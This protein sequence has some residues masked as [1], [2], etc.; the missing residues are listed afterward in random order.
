MQSDVAQSI[1]RKV[2]VT[3]AGEEQARLSSA[4]PVS[5]EVYET[6]RK[7]RFAKSN[8]QQELERN[9]A[10]FE[11]AISKDP[12]FA[13]A[14]VGLA[15][16]YDSLATVF[17]GAPPEGAREKQTRAALKALE[18]DSGNAEA[19]VLLAHVLR[20]Q[21]HW[22]NAEAEYK[23]ALALNPNDA[24]AHV[25]CATWFLCQGQTEE[26][27]AWSRRAREL[28]PLGPTG[29]NI[30]YILFGA[31]HYDE[32][33][34]DMQDALALRPDDALAHWFLGFALIAKDQPAEAIPEL[35]KAVA[36]TDYGPGAIGV[37]IRAYAHAGRRKV[38]L[39]LLA[40]LKLR[41]HAGYVASGAFVNAYLG[42]GDNAQAFV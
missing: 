29:T 4:R 26:A 27:V 1:A 9:I 20:K 37:L 38:A 10:S 7:G 16:A 19:H 40:D 28:D 14:Y 18:L 24:A 30:G 17:V 5:P 13:P 15:G 32:A 41:N 22:A 33:I 25:G 36:L 6:C 34:Q 42:L 3:V 2:E 11:E 23:R 12:T 39:R 35:E 31:R 8:S 21:W